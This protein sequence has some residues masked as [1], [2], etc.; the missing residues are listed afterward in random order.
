[1]DS[2]PLFWI[3]SS[4]LMLGLSLRYLAFAYTW[5]ARFECKAFV[6]SMRAEGRKCFGSWGEK[7]GLGNVWG[8]VNRSKCLGKVWG[9][10]QCFLSLSQEVSD[11]ASITIPGKQQ[12]RPKMQGLPAKLDSQ[13]VPMLRQEPRVNMGGSNH[14]RGKG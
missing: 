5:I 9:E 13:R 6:A 11:W 1:M 10:I 14:L 3:V 4:L 7:T 12:H 2:K 8:N